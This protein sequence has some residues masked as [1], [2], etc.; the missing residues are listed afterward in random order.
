[1]L[2][3]LFSIRTRRVVSLQILW[4][5]QFTQTWPK[6]CRVRRHFDEV[7]CRYPRTLYHCDTDKTR[8]NGYTIEEKH[9]SPEQVIIMI[10][11][12]RW[13]DHIQENIKVK[14]RFAT[15]HA[16]LV[17]EIQNN[18]GCLEAAG[19]D[20]E[21]FLQP[22]KYQKYPHRSWLGNWLW[23]LIVKIHGYCYLSTGS[24][25]RNSTLEI[26]GVSSAGAELTRFN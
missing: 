5:S 8:D 21:R 2:L 4:P 12:T 15:Y 17:Q 3:I 14:S 11:A 19:P 22:R 9:K 10:I 23:A 18:G 16:I 1:M 7:S 20:R 13:S 6:R 26:L 25:Y 24:I